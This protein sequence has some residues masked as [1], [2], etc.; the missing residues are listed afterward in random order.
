MVNNPT[1]FLVLQA[2]GPLDDTV[3]HSILAVEW[4]GTAA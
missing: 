3:R 1:Q 2:D 4:R